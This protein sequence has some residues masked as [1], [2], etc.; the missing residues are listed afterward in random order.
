MRLIISDIVTLMINTLIR[1]H[2]ALGRTFQV[3]KSSKIVQECGKK[4]SSSLR[5]CDFIGNAY[6]HINVS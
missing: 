5:N 6:T 4:Q 2:G 3:S 1:V